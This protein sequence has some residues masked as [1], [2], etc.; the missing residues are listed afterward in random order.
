MRWQGG[1]GRSVGEVQYGQVEVA[2]GADTLRMVVFRKDVAAYG[3]VMVA[4]G[5]V[6][7]SGGTAQRGM[8]MRRLVQQGDG[9]VMYSFPQ[10]RG[11]AQVQ[12]SG[13]LVMFS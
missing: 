9:E 1:V 5:I 13:C 3:L 7:R 8:S 10:R 6:A 2:R 12:R 11:R 4:C